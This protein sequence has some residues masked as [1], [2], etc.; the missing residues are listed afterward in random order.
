[1]LILNECASYNFVLDYSVDVDKAVVLSFGD[2]KVYFMIHFTQEYI[3]H[4]KW[5]I[6][7]NR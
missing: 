5:H 4:F 6:I 1:M 3:I 2:N 7:K